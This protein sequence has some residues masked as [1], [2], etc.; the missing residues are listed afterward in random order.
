MRPIF[1]FSGVFSGDGVFELYP[2]IIAAYW[3]AYAKVLKIKF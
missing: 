1:S 2:K 3:V